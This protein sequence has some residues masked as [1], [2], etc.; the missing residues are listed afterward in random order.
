M[1]SAE[2]MS[3]FAEVLSINGDEC[4]DLYGLARIRAL[5][6]TLAGPF[7]SRLDQS[8]G[9][10]C[11]TMDSGLSILQVHTFLYSTSQTAFAVS[12]WKPVN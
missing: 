9:Y 1:E 4:L 11:G 3:I 10:G 12:I 2:N 8:C 6:E 7:D 5:D